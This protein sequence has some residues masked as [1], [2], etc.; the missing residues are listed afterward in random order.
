MGSQMTRLLQ[1][2]Y[3]VGQS[4]FDD[5][6]SARAELA[7]SK[8]SATSEAIAEKTDLHSVS[9]IN[10]YLERWVEIGTWAKTQMGIKNME[11]LTSEAVRTFLAEKFEIGVSYS[12]FSQYCAAI[13]KL[14]RALNSYASQ[15]GKAA[16]HALRDFKD[17]RTEAKAELPR[18]TGTR[19]YSDTKGL[20]SALSGNSRLVATIQR[21]SGARL[22]EATSIRSE[23]LRGLSIDP[24][25]GKAIG[26]YDFIGKGGKENTAHVSVATYRELERFIIANG[27]VLKLNVDS[28][29]ADLKAAA[30]KSGQ[31][32]NGSHG[33]RWVF[34][35][36]RMAEL[37][38][39]GV[40]HAQSLGIVSSE[41]GHNRI[42]ITLRYLS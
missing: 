36:A 6:Q 7:E 2:V 15:A 13:T 35:Q 39:N 20:L 37:Q 16:N 21:E 31:V 33:L 22:A 1:E 18:F 17:L 41:M 14:E 27:G 23:Q 9:T 42:E 4:K 30:V 8:L 12:H 28:Y 29:R 38:S 34:A 32:Y 10:N 26:S 25:T 40:G 11:Q 5:K 3:A 24:H 19:A